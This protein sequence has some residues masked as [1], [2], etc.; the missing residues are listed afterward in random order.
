MRVTKNRF[1]VIMKCTA[2]VSAA[3]TVLLFFLHH[4]FPLPWLSAAA[5]TAGTVC[6]HFS[7]RLLIGL[8]VPKVFQSVDPGHKWFLPKPFENKLY[9]FLQIKK[10]KKYV[11]TYAPETFFLELPLSQ[12]ARTMCISELVHTVI[13]VFSFVPLLF[14]IPFGEFPVFLI[15]S[16]LAAAVD[17]IFILLQRYNRPRV[18]RLLAKRGH[19]Q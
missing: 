5:I 8:I 9:S 15:T 2:A 19:S 7:V 12:I 1:P 18:I 6:Y 13:A 16:V 3:A 11:P 10:W 4:H 17:C 14:S